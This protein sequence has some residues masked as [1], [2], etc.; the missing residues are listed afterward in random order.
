M[1]EPALLMEQITKDTISHVWV[2]T[3]PLI[4][5]AMAHS[6]GEANSEDLRRAVIAGE[7]QLF[8]VHD[9]E[10]VHFAFV[11]ELVDYPRFMSMR[12][13]ALAGRTSG[14]LAVCMR[15][16]WPKVIEWAQA[17]GV[18]KFEAACHPTMAKML[19]RY[20]FYTKYHTV[21]LDAE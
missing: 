15:D 12:I 17:Q 18:T 20:G 1:T 5:K 7:C 21:F 9:K 10:T 8:V 14:I 4:N 16:F 2:Q 6:N 13:I 19:R 3:R 11:T